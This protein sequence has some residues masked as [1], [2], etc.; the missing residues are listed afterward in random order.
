M[1]HGVDVGGEDISEPVSVGQ[2]ASADR[3]TFRGAIRLAGEDDG[4]VSG[5]TEP[6]YDSRP[7]VAG[8]SDDEDL[9]GVSPSWLLCGWGA[10]PSKAV[11]GSGSWLPRI[12]T[13][14]EC[15]SGE[16]QR[17][18]RLAEHDGSQGG[19]DDRRQQAEHRDGGDRQSADA[20]EPQGVGEQTADQPEPQVARRTAPV[21][22]FRCSLEHA[23]RD[24]D[25]AAGGELPA[26]E[27]DRRYTVR[28]A[29]ALG[30]SHTQC[31]RHRAGEAGCDSDRVEAGLRAEHDQRDAAQ[32]GQTP[33]ET[34]GRR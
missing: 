11:R 29:P 22:G 30:Q 2:V 34:P 19:G 12:A 24:K 7:D 5:S 1:D 8:A 9:H 3:H 10:D 28:S 20:A 6:F 32:S 27:R 26:G 23:D 13:Q 4:A 16:L 33:A 18:E 15:E 31:H 17:R 21:E 14:C 25:N